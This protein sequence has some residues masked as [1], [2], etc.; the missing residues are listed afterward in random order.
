MMFPNNKPGRINKILTIT[1]LLTLSACWNFHTVPKAIKRNFTYCYDGKKTGIESKLNINGYFVS[2]EPF[3]RYMIGNFKK[4]EIDT[5][6]NYTMFFEDGIFVDNFQDENLIRKLKGQSNI[7]QYIKEII[8]DKGSKSSSL[9]YESGRW[10]RY[11][12]NGDTIKGQYI[13]HYG[14]LWPA[15]EIWYKIIDRNTFIEFNWK[16]IDKMSK[17]DLQNEEAYKREKKYYPSKFIPLP[18]KPSS[19]CWLKKEDWFWCKNR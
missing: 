14:Y 7:Q 2:A 15:F 16:S 11:I 9:F 8:E 6:Y 17:T 19:D 1:F 18:A 5:F 13:A 12:I 3:D 10:G 4:H